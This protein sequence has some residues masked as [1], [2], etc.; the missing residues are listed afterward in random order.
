[1]IVKDMMPSFELYQ[2]ASLQD[3]LE[4]ADRF[5]ADGW[6]MAGGNDSL[7]WFK[8]RAKRPV[9]VIDITGIAELK[10]VRERADG[11]EIGA[12][13]TLTEI[14]RDP[15]I[16]DRFRILADAAR[17]VASPQIRNNG[18]IGGNVS[19]DTRCWYY[20]YGLPCYRAGGNTCYADTPEGMNREHALFE[21]DRCVAVTPSDTAPV[22]VVLEAEMLLASAGGERTVKAED[23][24]IGP[25][26]DITRMTA[27]EPGEILSAIRIPN[28]WAGAKFY[29][30]KVADRQ[31]WDFPLVNVAS[32]LVV[33]DGVVERARVACGGVA[34]TPRLLAVV[35]DVVRGNAVDDQLAQLAGQSV[36]RG[37]RP[38]NYN[39]FKVPLMQNLVRRAVRDA[40]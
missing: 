10:G 21:A 4:L 25:A 31:T 33:S 36:T 1:M 3:A 39:H 19:Q 11:I 34:C 30:E 5:G 24:F 15:L 18:T 20:R 2:P 9:A 27:R 12:L 7:A 32:A 16:Q 6:V 38:L 35:G 14:E 17:R 22:L 13:T 23:F 28:T 37:A 26:V 8:D 29:F 40:A